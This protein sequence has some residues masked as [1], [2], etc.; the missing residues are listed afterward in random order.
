M[1]EVVPDFICNALRADLAYTS[2]INYVEDF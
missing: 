1:F 2:S